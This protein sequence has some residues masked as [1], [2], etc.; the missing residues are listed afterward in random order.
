MRISSLK[1][2]YEVAELKSIS[3]VSNNLHI[4]QPALSHQLSKL[5]KDLGVK[6]LERSNKG[7]E[8]TN[9]GKIMY[10]YA[11]QMLLLH[12]NLIDNIGD[13]SHMK[14][15]LKINILNS[16]INF[17]LGR[18][19]KDKDKIFKNINISINGQRDDNE[20]ALLIHNRAD[21][22]VGCRKIED[23]DLMSSYIGSDKLMLVSKQ[24]ID[25]DS[26]KDISIA[27][28]E[29]NSNIISNLLKN[30]NQ[31]NICLR[32][33]SLEVIKSYLKNNDVAAIVPKIAVEE[34]LK[35]GELVGLCSNKY[36]VDYDLYITYRKDLEIDLKKRIKLFKTELEKILSKENIQIAM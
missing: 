36:D 15:E 16:H 5:E 20:K 3:K 7:V 35:S 11:K 34:E 6:L 30:V 29:D 31:A 27:T 9:K 4:S 2:F 12:D 25:C 1:Y 32:T 13:D 26:I 28:L 10:N 19:I 23:S 8:L 24:N 18:I 22:V 21:I 14:K 17:L 33:D